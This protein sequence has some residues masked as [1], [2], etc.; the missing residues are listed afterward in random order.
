MTYGVGEVQPG[1][2]FDGRDRAGSAGGAAENPGD[3]ITGA[4]LSVGVHGEDYDFGELPPASISGLVHGELNGD[5][6][7]DPGE[8]L[9]GG[10]TIHLLDAS[11]NR[12][13]STTTDSSGRYVFTIFAPA[14]TACTRSSRSGYLQGKT[15]AGS[16]GAGWRG[17]I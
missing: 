8:P 16:A 10:V 2:Y 13:A 12:V 9:L 7:P 3:R 11:S 14:S 5:C 6:I 1:G 4:L 17:P 15:H